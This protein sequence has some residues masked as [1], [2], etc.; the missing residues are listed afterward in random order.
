VILSPFRRL[1]TRAEIDA[2]LD[3]WEKIEAID[4]DDCDDDEL[5]RRNALIAL[6]E[7]I[8]ETHRQMRRLIQ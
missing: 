7:S 1:P 4:P 5:A 3:R 6:A 8:D 2:R